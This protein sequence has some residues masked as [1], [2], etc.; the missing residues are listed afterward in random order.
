[1]GYKKDFLETIVE[2]TL[3]CPNLHDGFLKYLNGIVSGRK[4]DSDM[5]IL[6]TGSA[7]NVFYLGNEAGFSVS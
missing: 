5:N 1:M 6:V 2:Y 4:E 7:G 3:R